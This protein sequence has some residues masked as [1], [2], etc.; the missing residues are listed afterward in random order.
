MRKVDSMTEPRSAADRLELTGAITIREIE[1]VRRDLLAQIQS[2]GL[3]SKKPLD[4]DL[5]GVTEADIS[6]IQLM[7]AAA[8]S[9]A[10]IRLARPYPEAVQQVLARS[11]LDAAASLWTPKESIAES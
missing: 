1:A 9:G 5:S 2:N 3:E 8:K 6:L 4:I 10:P 11:G 7:L